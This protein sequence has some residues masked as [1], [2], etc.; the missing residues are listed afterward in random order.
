MLF[1]CLNVLSS[2]IRFKI[3]LLSLEKTKI[4]YL[5]LLE[6]SS[7]GVLATYIDTMNFNVLFVTHK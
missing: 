6:T 7:N 5:V 4:L 2:K 3:R 1:I